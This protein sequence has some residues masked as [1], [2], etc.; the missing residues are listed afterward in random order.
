MSKP[1]ELNT[2]YSRGVVDISDLG[3]YFKAGYPLG[4]IPSFTLLLV[5]N[6]HAVQ[7]TLLSKPQ[8]SYSPENPEL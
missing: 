7:L 4:V 3:D 2:L 8:N 5:L 1:R 6:A